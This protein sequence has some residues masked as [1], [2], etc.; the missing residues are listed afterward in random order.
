MASLTDVQNALA[1]AVEAAIAT[2]GITMPQQV[3]IG[4]PF[5]PSLTEILGQSEGQVTV[6]P[7]AG[8]HVDRTSRKPDWKVLTNAAPELTATLDATKTILTLGGAIKA[9]DVIHAFVGKIPQDAYTEVVAGDTV[10]AIG[11]RLQTALAAF[12]TLAGVVLNDGP[13]VTLVVSGGTFDVVNIGGTGS[14]IREIAR[15]AQ[16]IRVS[17]WSPDPDTRDQIADVIRNAVGVGTTPFLPAA[18]DGSAI[19]VKLNGD[20]P[21]DTSQSSYSLYEHHFVFECE[22]AVTQTVAATQIEG[23][24][25]TINGGAPLYTGG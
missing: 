15:Y 4:Q 19:R 3:G 24:E 11:Q 6:F 16:S 20:M 9:G 25:L 17:V 13:P 8:T 1:D 7:V 12:G 23:V 14:L 2:A 18:S 5:G 10:V 21:V 22:Y